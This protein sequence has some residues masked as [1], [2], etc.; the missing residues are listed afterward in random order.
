MKLSLYQVDA[1]TDR[2]FGGNPAAVVPLS[3][4]LP[5]NVLMNIAIENNLSETAFF[6][7]Q[8]RHYEL[9]WFTV[10]EEIDLCGHA[11]LASAHVLF[12][13]MGYKGDVITFETRQ[14]GSLRVSRSDK[15]L[16]LDFPERTP[17]PITDIPPA[18]IASLGGVEPQEVLLSRDYVVVYGSEDDVRRIVP[19]YAVMDTLKRRVCIT[20]KGHKVDFCQPFLLSG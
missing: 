16:T 10:L 9:R 6:V 17:S 4:W 5:D 7:P 8:G 2:I 13:H 11:T 18:L 20:A 19:D 3:H 15:L 12:R 1:F 14:A